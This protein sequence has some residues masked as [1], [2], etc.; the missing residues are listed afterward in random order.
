MKRE[1]VLAMCTPKTGVDAQNTGELGLDENEGG[2]VMM[3]VAIMGCAER[4]CALIRSNART[5]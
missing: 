2:V 4:G 3:V 5:S 1:S